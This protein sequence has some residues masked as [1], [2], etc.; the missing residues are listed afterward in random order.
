VN[1]SLGSAQTARHV[2]EIGLHKLNKNILI[3]ALFYPVIKKNYFSAL[4]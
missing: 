3:I 1:Q 2:S 4:V